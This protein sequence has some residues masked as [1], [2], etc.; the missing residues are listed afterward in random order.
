MSNG[1]ITAQFDTDTNEPADQASTGRAAH[2]ANIGL[3]PG[4]MLTQTKPVVDTATLV[5]F[6]FDPPI[7]AASFE[8]RPTVGATPTPD[9][10]V[11]FTYSA[12][13]G[14]LADAFLNEANTAPRET[15]KLDDGIQGRYFNGALI[16]RIDVKGLGTTPTLTL[17]IG[18]I[19]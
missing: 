7:K 9:E 5:T 19:S 3:P 2:V 8:L 10:G 18:G 16:S 14:P 1:P 17:T 15:L 12:D 11:V 13:N 4:T 6:N